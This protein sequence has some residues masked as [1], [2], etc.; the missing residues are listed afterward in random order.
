MYPY[1]NPNMRLGTNINHL[2]NHIG[3]VPIAQLPHIVE[4]SHGVIKI[5]FGDSYI[6]DEY[7]KF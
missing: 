1:L 5:I 4:E 2:P 3:E 7:N 6:D